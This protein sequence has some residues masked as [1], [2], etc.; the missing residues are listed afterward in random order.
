MSI[1]TLIPDQLFDGERWYAARPVT[2]ENEHV[3][4][5]DT[6]AGVAP[7][8]V[9]GR[10]VPGFIDVQ[11]NGGGGVLFNDAPTIATITR[12][13]AAHARFGTTGFLPTLITDSVAAMTKAADVVSAALRARTPGLLGIHFEGPHL[14]VA[15]KGVHRAHLIR[16]VG[17]AEWALFSRRDLGARVVTVAPEMVPP[18]DIARLVG[19]GVRVCLG[20]SDADYETVE[21]ALRAGATGFTHLFNA[22]SPLTARDPGMVGAAL[23]DEASWC[24]LILDG[25]HVHRETAKLALKAKP[26]GK[27]MWVTDA[28]PLVG[29]DATEFELLGARIRREGARL[30]DE[31]G[32]LAGSVLDMA[33]AVR[34]GVEQL[35]LALE[36]SLRMAARHP[37]DFLGLGPHFGRI[38]PNG[39]ADLVLLG[40]QLDVTTTWIRGQRSTL[41]RDG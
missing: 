35:G 9:P 13:G 7:T 30:V 4:A 36:T 6:V 24:G 38:V 40:S 32:R 20:H 2:I 21:S 12:I 31:A 23:M 33:S 28:M 8:R 37:A 15:K 25:C 18:D 41:D 19:L 5:F 39:Y 16:P 11:V 3:V 17:D 22:M 1:L 34:N 27:V 29:T 10:L 26:A 14:A